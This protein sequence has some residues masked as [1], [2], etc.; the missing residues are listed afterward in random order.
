LA[1]LAR[2]AAYKEA[3]GDCNVPRGWA[4]DPRLA[5]WVTKQR[6]LKRQLDRGEPS[7]GMTADRAERLAALGFV[8]DPP[9]AGTPNEA[10]WEAQEARL[11]AYKAAHGDYNVPCRWAK[12]QQLANWVRNQR[13]GKRKLDR[14]ESSGKCDGMTAERV[15]RLTALGFAWDP[16]PGHMPDEKRWEAQLARLATYKAEHGDCNVP[17][18]WS[19]DPQLGTW[20]EHQR[21]GKRQLRPSGSAAP[22]SGSKGM[23]VDRAARLTALGFVWN[24]RAS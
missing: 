13:K 4:G 21:T 2:L 19:E 9:V 24:P 10:A 7:Q 5:R 6:V 16:G 8:W 15:A 18:D 23:T 11:V 1:Q 17:R 22:A 12:D 14:D 20:V 3:H